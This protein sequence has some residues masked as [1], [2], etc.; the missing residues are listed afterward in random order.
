MP[1]LSGLGAAVLA[2]GIFLMVRE[3]AKVEPVVETIGLGAVL[4][5]IGT[6]LLDVGLSG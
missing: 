5:G 1:A 6:A 3:T 4:V 2:V